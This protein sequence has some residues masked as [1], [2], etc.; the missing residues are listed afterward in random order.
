MFAHY[1]AVRA[2]ALAEMAQIAGGRLPGRRL[3]ELVFSLPASVLARSLVAL[4]RDLAGASL[5]LAALAALR[6]FGV[7]PALELAAGAVPIRLL[8]AGETP[9]P[10]RGPLLVVANHPGLFDALALFAAADRDDLVTLAARRP[11]FEALPNLRRRLLAIDPGAA[12][13]LALRH[14]LRHLRR[15]GAVL[16]FPAGRIEPDPSVTPRGAPLLQPWKPGLG[17]LLAAAARSCPDLR[18][19]TALV[20]GVISPRALAVA[21]ALGRT[22]GLTDALVPLIQLTFPGFGDAAVRVRFGPAEPVD[23]A[24]G[25]AAP[26]LRARIEAMATTAA[27]QTAAAW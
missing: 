22:L 18:V 26:R 8:D 17:L 10:R 5:R 6:R 23:R 4:D 7:D 1:P 27:A 14:A 16:H 2:I 13:G 20:S 3:A 24:A 11:L 15:G 25:D 19:A 9:L 12:G 21:G